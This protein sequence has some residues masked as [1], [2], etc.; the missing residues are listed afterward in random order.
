M[1]ASEERRRVVQMRA[2]AERAA[3]DEQLAW[4]EVT[5]SM[6]AN[7]AK[8]RASEAGDGHGRSAAF[9]NLGAMW[10]SASSN[11]RPEQRAPDQ[12][13]AGKLQPPVQPLSSAADPLTSSARGDISIDFCVDAIA[14]A[15]LRR[16]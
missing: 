2:E 8:A 9:R 4:K 12:H 5:E 1:D 3:L 6:K 11:I 10:G 16:R 13:A 15:R 7:G 14:A